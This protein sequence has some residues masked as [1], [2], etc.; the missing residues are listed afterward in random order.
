[1]HIFLGIIGIAIILF[2]LYDVLW[3]TLRLT[4][5]GPLTSWVTDVLWKLSLRSTKSHKQ[6]G[7]AGFGVVLFAVFL[8][9][10]LT[11]LGWT[12]VMSWSGPAIVDAQSGQP[13][14]FWARLYFTGYTLVTMGNGDYRPIGPVWQVLTA[15][16][17]ANGFF[18]I[19]LIITYLLPLVTEVINRRQLAV[20]ISGLGRTPQDVLGEAWNGSGFGLLANHFVMLTL[21]MTELGQGHLAYPVLHCFHAETRGEA[22][23]PSIAVLDEALTLMEAVAPEQKLDRVAIYPLRR[24]IQQFLSTLTEAHLEPTRVPPPPPAA[25]RLKAAGIP[26]VEEELRRILEGHSDRRRLLF[27]LVEQEGWDWQRDVVEGSPGKE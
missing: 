26:I 16:A 8:W 6:L 24:A 14:D 3:T 7:V 25:D 10:G 9:I 19:T 20:Y 17:S 13:A 1:V 18:L 21:P 12:L 22:L 11:L 27:G 5:G 15:V 2:V 4:G 23:A